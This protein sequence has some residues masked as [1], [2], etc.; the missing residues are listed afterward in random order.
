MAASFS[1]NN[2]VSSD[3]ITTTTMTCD[4]NYP[5]GGYPVTPGMFGDGVTIDDIVPIAQ[6]NQFAAEYVS[7]TQSIKIL[8]DPGTGLAEV[9]GTTDLHTLLVQLL[10]FGR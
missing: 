9:V 7:A 4:A 2:R 1:Q 10:V 6:S 5:T 3:Y 8:Q